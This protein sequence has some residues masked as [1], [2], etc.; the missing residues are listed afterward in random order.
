MMRVEAVGEQSIPVITL[1]QPWAS[2]VFTPDSEGRPLKKHETRGFRYPARLRG[3]VIA[4]HAAKTF[5]AFRHI[6]PELHD[7]CYDAFGCRYND[8]LP[9][10][11]IIGTVRLGDCVPTD[12]PFALPL[13]DDDRI[14][15]DWSPGRFAWRLN[16]VTPLPAPV[17]ARGKQGWWKIEPSLLFPEPPHASQ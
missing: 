2:L 3:E 4:I 1:W 10:G 5:P 12:D 17:P 16:E 13:D 11:A 7:L 8:A 9:L 15:G 6:S 14:A